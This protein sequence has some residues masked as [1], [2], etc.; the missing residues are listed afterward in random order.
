MDEQEMEEQALIMNRLLDDADAIKYILN[1]LQVLKSKKGEE[2]E[3]LVKLMDDERKAQKEKEKFDIENR[4]KIEKI[5]EQRDRAEEWLHRLW[6][7]N[8]L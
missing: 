5:R 7:V 4:Y 3:F 2:D 8:N 6:T 1:T